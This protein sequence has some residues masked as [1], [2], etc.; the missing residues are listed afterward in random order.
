MLF[1]IKCL[2]LARKVSKA[3]SSFSFK[4]PVQVNLRSAGRNKNIFHILKRLGVLYLLQPGTEAHVAEV[5]GEE[6][7]W[8][9]R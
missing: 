7:A 3:F 2:L 8:A 9:V 6:G 5:I 4:V 1:T